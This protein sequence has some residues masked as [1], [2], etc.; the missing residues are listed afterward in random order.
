MTTPR[1]PLTDRILGCAIEVHRTLGPGLLESAY[2]E[3][4]CYELAQAGIACKRQVP[5]PVR[6]KQVSLECGYRMDILTEDQVV[7]ELK[8][9]EKPLPVHDAQMLTYLRLSGCRVGLLMNFNVP[10]PRDGIKRLV[11]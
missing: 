5:L 11:L 6:Y 3:C 1:D 10:V 7:V 9:V 8:T 4:L 2:E